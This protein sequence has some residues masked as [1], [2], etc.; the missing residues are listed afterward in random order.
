[1]IL[2]PEVKFLES[3]KS[4]SHTITPNKQQAP[5][6]PKPKVSSPHAEL[7]SDELVGTEFKRKGSVRDRIKVSFK[8]QHTALG[9]YHMN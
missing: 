5:S 3:P 8:G 2:N 7:P 6:S 1:M 4:I 9:Q